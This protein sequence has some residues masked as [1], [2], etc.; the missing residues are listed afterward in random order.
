M[1]PSPN[2]TLSLLTAFSELAIPT[3]Q[4]ASGASTTLALPTDIY[5]SDTMT[6][7]TN[8]GYSLD[9]YL[10]P[11][12]GFKG[13]FNIIGTA[14]QVFTS[15]NYENTRATITGAEVSSSAPTD[16]LDSMNQFVVPNSNTLKAYFYKGDRMWAFSCDLNPASCQADYQNSSLSQWYAGIGRQANNA[17]G[18]S[19]YPPPSRVDTVSQWYRNDTT[20]MTYVYSGDRVWPFSCITGSG[21]TAQ[22]TKLLSSHWPSGVGP[23]SRSSLDAIS[24]FVVP[25]TNTLKGYIYNGNQMWAYTCDRTNY[26]GSCT[27]F[28]TNTLSGFWGGIPSSTWAAAGWSTNT[29]P[30]DYI[31]S[32]FQYYY[33]AGTLKSYV[34]RGNRIWHYICDSAGCRAVSTSTLASMFTLT[35]DL[36][37]QPIK[38]QF[39]WPQ[40]SQSGVAQIVGVSDWGMDG[41]YQNSGYASLFLANPTA[42]LGRYNRLHTEQNAR[43]RATNAPLPV[44][45]QNGAWNQN[46]LTATKN[47]GS[48][49][50]F[51]DGWTYP[52]NT[53]KK[54]NAHW[55][56]NMLVGKNHSMAYLA[57]TDK[58]ILAQVAVPTATPTNTPTRTPTPIPPTA[59]PT[60]TPTPIPPTNTPT[61]T[62]T[63]TFTPTRTPT[64]IPPTNTP[65]RTPTRTPTA[66]FT[67]TRTP[68]PTFTPTRTP[69]L[70][71]P[72]NTPTRTPTATFTPTRTPTLVPPTNTPTRT[73]TP[74]ATPTRTPTPIVATNTPTRT[75][76]PI[77][78]T[79]T[80]IPPTSTPI[81]PSPTTSCKPGDCDCNGSVNLQDLVALLGSYGKTGMDRAH[82]NLDGDPTGI[83]N[84]FD[85]TILLANFGK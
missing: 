75:P 35:G 67:P 11:S 19:T 72:T 8:I 68:T 84:S 22:P 60:R 10:S 52:A 26:P 43:G 33:P 64:P 54:V 34:M 25:G 31:D 3:N 65:T 57:L 58:K 81:V 15:F 79:N 73:P 2:Y 47:S 70:V 6:R 17:D 76:T 48:L 21:C 14:G 27:H 69:T 28:L 23:S 56:F 42:S 5:T 82:G 61:R 71:P 24:E 40:F 32:I 74:T 55:W 78:A 53:D 7:L 50:P 80:P 39:K 77:I 44:N 12:F 30:T 20:L 83:V 85:M 1:S 36:F 9:N 45:Y 16:S 29:P 59:T 37:N 46:V 41:S 4:L 66:T 18:W 49:H 38:Y 13:P 51:M 62:P 63:A